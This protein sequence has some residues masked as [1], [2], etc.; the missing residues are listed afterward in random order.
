MSCH[1][2]HLERARDHEGDSRTA[3]C[4]NYSTIGGG[5]ARPGGGGRGRQRSQINLPSCLVCTKMAPKQPVSLIIDL[6]IT[7][8]VI[9]YL[10][11][12]NKIYSRNVFEEYINFK[13]N[14]LLKA[15]W[16][17]TCSKFHK[18]YTPRF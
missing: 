6:K 13:K 18:S 16:S 4:A 9:F 12:L 14:L 5:S 15:L 8:N 10:K 7:K 11:V 17:Y 1:S 2:L 3:W